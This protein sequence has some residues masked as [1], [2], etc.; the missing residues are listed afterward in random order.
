M[1]R[2]QQMV[3]AGCCM[4]AQPQSTPC[5]VCISRNLPVLGADSWCVGR[6]PGP[7]QFLRKPVRLC[8]CV[9]MLNLRAWLTV[10][11]QEPNSVLGTVQTQSSGDN[12]ALGPALSLEGLKRPHKK[13][14]LPVPFRQQKPLGQRERRGSH[15]LLHHGANDFTKSQ[16]LVT[17]EKI[18]RGCCCLARQQIGQPSG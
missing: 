4:S 6:A 1:G 9:A 2:A 15:E 11:R 18:S 16:Y 5:P 3:T 7:C 10:P 8:W 17:G 13:T 12:D 14:S